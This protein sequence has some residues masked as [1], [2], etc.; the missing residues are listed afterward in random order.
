MR[1]W[2]TRDDALGT[3]FVVVDAYEEV[4]VPLLTGAGSEWLE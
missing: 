3:I 4:D 1:R 2:W